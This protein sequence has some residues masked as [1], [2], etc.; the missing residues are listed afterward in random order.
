MADSDSLLLR[1]A[2]GD[3]A[4][5]PLLL[6]RYGALVWSIARKQARTDE[7]ED[8]V[9]E[10]FIQIWKQAE[11]YDPELGSEA[12]FITTIARRRLIDHR[13][14]VGRRGEAMELPEEM[15]VEVPG[16]ADPLELSEEARVAK[17]ALDKLRPEQ[18]EVLHMALVEGRTHTEIA[19]LTSLPL[20]TVKSH[21][22]RGL[23]R[24]RRLLR[25][26]PEE[27]GRSGS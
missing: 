10:V 21:A 4:A 23:E 16:V 24:V 17:Q 22:R 19:E 27:A 12:A 9:Q 6:D 2:R 1:V 18:R 5:V 13:R 8:L 3:A 25:V 11:R 15:P 26:E 20:G 7:A 14:K